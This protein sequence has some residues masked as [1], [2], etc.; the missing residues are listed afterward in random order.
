[1]G[2]LHLSFSRWIEDLRTYLRNG[3]EEPAFRNGYADNNEVKALGVR[4]LIGSVRSVG[5][6]QAAWTCKMQPFARWRSNF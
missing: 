1:M 5:M 2:P 4:A 3:Y 6:C